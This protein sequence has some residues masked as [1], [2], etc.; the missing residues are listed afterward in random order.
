MFD[1]ITKQTKHKLWPH[2][3]KALD[4]AINHLRNLNSPCLIRMP[5]GTGKT[6][7]IACLTK[8]S[9]Q[10]SSLVLTP[11]AHLRSQ[12]VADLEKDF[13][14]KVGLTPN[15]FEV[16]SMFPS[17]ARDILKSG[18]P[19]VLVA[20]FATL[21]DLRRNHAD[22]YEILGKTV[23]LAIVDEGHYEPAIEWG[24]SVKGLNTKTVLLTATPYRNDLKLFRITDPERSTH[25]YTHKQAVKDKII[26]KLRVEELTSPTDISSLS[27]SF[28]RRWK[29][30]KRAKTLPSRHPR[31]IICCSG[32]TDIEGAVAH[33]RTAGLKTI[34][35]H[36]QFK[37]STN[38]CLLEAVPGPQ[39]TDSEIWVHQHKLMEGLDDHRFCCV[40]FFAR[41]RND[42]KL[43]QQIGRVLRR[44]ANDSSRPGGPPRALGLRCGCRLECVPGV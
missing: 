19:Q 21:N 41:I 6:G 36:E 34:G 25:R 3:A 15:D 12:M 13:W 38:P 29:K 27:S 28:A 7:I 9:N 43:I 18:K 20:T 33:L 5:T 11:W 17:T 8:V 10:H 22:I 24:K 32:A 42:R 4:F 39:C 23:S 31:A 1:A 44:D 2:Q 16:V 26:R 30:A 37:T 35:I 14:K 40:A